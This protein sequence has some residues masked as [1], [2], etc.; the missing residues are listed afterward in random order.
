MASPIKLPDDA[1]QRRM[2][3]RQFSNELERMTRARARFMYRATAAAI[4]A[5]LLL[6]AVVAVLLTRGYHGGPQ[7]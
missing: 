5:V 1:Y 7:P 3:A 6:A 2:R 4:V